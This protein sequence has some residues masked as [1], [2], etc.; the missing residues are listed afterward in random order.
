MLRYCFALSPF[1]Q[2]ATALQ[3]PNDHRLQPH[4]HSVNLIRQQKHLQH[5]EAAANN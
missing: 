1:M 2:R 3:L 4:T 5:L